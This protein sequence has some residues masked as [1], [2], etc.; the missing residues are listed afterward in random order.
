MHLRRRRR[1]LPR[2]NET[3]NPPINQRLPTVFIHQFKVPKAQLLSIQ[4]S[5]GRSK[6]R[7]FSH[8][9]RNLHFHHHLHHLIRKLSTPK[10][11]NHFCFGGGVPSFLPHG[12]PK[13][14][15]MKKKKSSQPT[16]QGPSSPRLICLAL[17]ARVLR[18]YRTAY[19]PGATLRR[20]TALWR[21]RV[22]SS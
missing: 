21:Y 18:I 6:G 8:S 1:L 20:S 13:N 11:T 10:K 15:S 12:H 14:L 9:P 2:L 5:K 16:L 7:T 19:S 22:D 3:V 4:Y 17:H